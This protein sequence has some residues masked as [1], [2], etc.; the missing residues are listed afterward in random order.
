[1]SGFKFKVGDRVRLAATSYPDGEKDGIFLDYSVGEE[2]LILDQWVPIHTDGWSKGL[3]IISVDSGYYVAESMIEL[4]EEKPSNEERPPLG[5]K[6]RNVHNQQRIQE[7]VAAIG[8]YTD[9][10]KPIP[11]EWIEEYNDLVNKENKQC[12][13][14]K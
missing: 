2:F 8:R 7:I 4:A 5:L 13:N 14:T 6:P 9:A 11:S 1:M 12:L 10:N 3:P